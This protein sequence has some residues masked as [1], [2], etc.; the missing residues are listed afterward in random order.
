MIAQVV[1]SYMCMSGG[2][3]LHA[4]DAWPNMVLATSSSSVQLCQGY[5]SFLIALN[6]LP[7]IINVCFFFFYK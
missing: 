5:L 6:V 3:K 4:K 7:I 2:G 1:G